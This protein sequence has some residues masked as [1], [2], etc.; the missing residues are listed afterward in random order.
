VV[1]GEVVVRHNVGA[2]GRGVGGCGV[3][4]PVGELRLGSHAAPPR[5]PALFRQGVCC[6]VPLRVRPGVVLLTPGVSAGQNGVDVDVLKDP[7]CLAA[8]APGR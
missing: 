6:V 2:S 8:R 3:T 5:A 1:A 4:H 7:K